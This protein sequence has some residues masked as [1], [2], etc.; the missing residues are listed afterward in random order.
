MNMYDGDG[1]GHEKFGIKFLH[2]LQQDKCREES[3]T[4]ISIL[5]ETMN[6]KKKKECQII[7]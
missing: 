5:L 7:W 4:L 2:G 1:K 3:V 6:K